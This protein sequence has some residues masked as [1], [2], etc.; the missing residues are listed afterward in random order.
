MT[1]I[2]NDGF[3]VVQLA[4]LK[5]L[6]KEA[7]AE[8]LSDIGLRVDSEEAIFEA[9]RDFA[10]LRWLREA[11][12]RTAQKIGW[13]VIAALVGA[14]LAIGKLGIDAYIHKGP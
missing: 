5:L 1:D 3:N 10:V 4:Q 9:R 8:V 6:V 14:V 13:A 11:L 12:G 2:P 7:V